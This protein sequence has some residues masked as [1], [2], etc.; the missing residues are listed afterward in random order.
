[1]F[2]VLCGQVGH[3]RGDFLRTT[4]LKIPHSIES[5]RFCT[6][7]GYILPLVESISKGLA[8][9]HV[10]ASHPTRRDSSFVPHELA[11]PRLVFRN[12]VTIKTE[13]LLWCG[14]V[15]ISPSSRKTQSTN[16]SV[17]ASLFCGGGGIR[18]RIPAILFHCVHKIDS[19]SW[20]ATRNVSLQ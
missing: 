5:Y 6:P 17:L 1:M 12:V 18:P 2:G 16:T 13:V 8:K 20:T 9:L 4:Y 15:R 10:F 3:S 14:S 7:F 11:S 19:V